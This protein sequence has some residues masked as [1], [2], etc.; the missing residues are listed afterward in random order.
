MIYTLDSF[1]A[2]ISSIRKRYQV[3]SS[4]RV[5]EVHTK[6]SALVNCLFTGH[7]IESKKEEEEEEIKLIPVWYC[8]SFHFFFSMKIIHWTTTG[9]LNGI[10]SIDWNRF[11]SILFILTILTCWVAIFKLVNEMTNDIHAW[12]RPLNR[13]GNKLY[14]LWNHLWRLWQCECSFSITI[15]HDF[16]FLFNKCSF[17]STDAFNFCFI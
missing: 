15:C 11:F 10:K 4:F 1:S 9:Y 2:L 16:L 5:N 7:R 8:C 6:N 13:D 3:S 14:L 12:S 17:H